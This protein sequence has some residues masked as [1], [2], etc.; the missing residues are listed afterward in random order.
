MLSVTI[1]LPLA[2]G[3]ALLALPAARPALVRAAALGAAAAT[4][5]CAAVLWGGYQR[6]GAG[7]QWR[8]HLEWVPSIGASYDVAVDGLSLSLIV[9]A[10]LLLAVVMLYVLPQR[11]RAK[12]HAFL[13]LVMASGLIG[14][15]ASRDLL[16]FYL[17]FEVALVPLYFII[18][19]WGEAERRYAATK[20]FLYTR[21][22]SLAMLLAF[23]GLYLAMQPHTFSLDAIIEAQPLAGGGTLA[24]LVLLGMLAGFGVKLPI[25]PLHNWLPDAHVQAPTEGS[26]MLAGIQLKLGA[27]GLMAVLLPTLPDTVARYGWPLLALGVFTLVYGALAALAQ[28]DFKRLVA[29]TSI[30]HMGYV[31]IGVAIAALASD[32]GTRALALN[33]A[34][35]Q[36]LSHGLLTGGMF[37]LAGIL[38][39]RAGTREIGRFGGLLG[40][41]PIYSGMLG[42]LAFASLGLPGFSGFVAEFQVIGA[43]LSLSVPAA[44]LIVLGLLVTTGLYLRI[45]TTMIMGEARAPEVFR[46]L[47]AREIASLLPLAVL[48]A[49]IGVAPALVMPLVR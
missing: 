48:S 15:F 4:L 22:G 27:Y 37:F 8:Q 47:D 43:A 7:L 46:D 21:A 49:A 41:V 26:V 32:P 23:L 12:L 30:N 31:L 18:G 1:F 14:V 35:L 25:V 40:R 2:C 13:F 5:A 34:A 29:Y 38:G 9:L 10:A 36:A 45:V 19:I 6:D 20:F 28:G 39:E 44:A 3:F 17:F 33:G 42:V 11:E 16:L 24:G